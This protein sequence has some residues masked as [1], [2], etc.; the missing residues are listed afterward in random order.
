M[1]KIK[2]KSITKKG[3]GFILETVKGDFKAVY[4]DQLESFVRMNSAKGFKRSVPP[5]AQGFMHLNMYN[6]DFPTNFYAVLK[7]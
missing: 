6:C 4:A 3:M 2:I 1:T 7:A 5:T